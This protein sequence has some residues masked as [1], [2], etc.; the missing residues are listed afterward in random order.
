MYDSLLAWLQAGPERAAVVRVASITGKGVC[1]HNTSGSEAGVC[2]Q[3]N[4]AAISFT[5]ESALAVACDCSEAS[6]CLVCMGNVSV[7]APRQTVGCS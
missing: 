7:Q 3:P 1:S 5:N 4:A 6:G 2:V